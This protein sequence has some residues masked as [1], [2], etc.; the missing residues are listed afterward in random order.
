[1]PAANTVQAT[2]AVMQVAAVVPTKVEAI[3]IPVPAIITD[4]IKEISQ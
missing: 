1:M 3:K 4:G 2:G